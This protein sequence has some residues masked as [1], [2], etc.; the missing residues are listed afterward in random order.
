MLDEQFDESLIRGLAST[1][2]TLDQGFPSHEHH[3]SYRLA[4]HVDPSWLASQEKPNSDVMSVG[5]RLGKPR[6]WLKGMDKNGEMHHNHIHVPV[7][8]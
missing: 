6:A 4:L 7:E 3:M 8:E 5:K 2:C 1:T